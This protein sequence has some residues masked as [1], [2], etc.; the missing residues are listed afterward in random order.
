MTPHVRN[1]LEE[2]LRDGWWVPIEAYLRDYDETREAVHTRRSKGIWQDG[3]H[4][5]FVAGGG[6]WIN[7]LAVNQWAAKSESR[8]GSR[9]GGTNKAR[10]SDSESPSSTG[11]SS[12]ANDST[13]SPPH[14]TSDT[15]PDSAARS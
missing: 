5:K 13:L 1:L 3:V 4:S 11:E 10:G 15:P 8:R 7:L 6:L 2:V 14:P 9:H 12:A